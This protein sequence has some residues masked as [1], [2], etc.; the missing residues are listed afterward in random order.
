MEANIFEKI[1]IGKRMDAT[2]IKNLHY[3]WRLKILSKLHEPL[4]ECHLKEFSNLTNPLLLEYSYWLRL[5]KSRKH[6][7]LHCSAN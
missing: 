3:K 7:H 6:A 1:C 4:G 2:A 5:G